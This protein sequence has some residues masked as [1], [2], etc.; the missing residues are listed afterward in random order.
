MGSGLGPR[1]RRRRTGKNF[2]GKGNIGHI[3]S[4]MRKSGCE[5]GKGLRY[6]GTG[7][8]G[9]LSQWQ[10]CLLMSGLNEHFALAPCIF[11]PLLTPCSCGPACQKW[12]LMAQPFN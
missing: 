9:S 5:Q 10:N 8:E 6:R 4:L 1:D 12:F 2:F 3:M 7:A 11:T